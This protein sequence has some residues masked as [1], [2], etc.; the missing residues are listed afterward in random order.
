MCVQAKMDK[1]GK[2]SEPEVFDVT[3]LIFV[4]NGILNVE[5]NEVKKEKKIG[6]PRAVAK[7]RW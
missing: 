5:E 6:G 3:D 1:D 7:G 2:I 4:S